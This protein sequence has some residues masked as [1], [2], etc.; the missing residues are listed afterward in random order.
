[1]SF[2]N[3]ICLFAGAALLAAA[4]GC[5]QPD[6]LAVFE[7][8]PRSASLQ[9]DALELR[10]PEELQPDLPADPVPDI[11]ADGVLNLSVEEVILWALRQNRDLRVQQYNPLI[12]GTFEQLER[13][14]FDPELFGQ[15]DYNEEQTTETARS[16]GTQFNVEATGA[17]G[18]AGIRQLLPT[19]TDIE[20]GIEQQ[21]TVSN[22]APE[23]QEA[24]AGLTVT[25]ALLRGFGPAVN[26]VGVRQAELET[27]ANIYELRGFTEALLAEAE[28]AYWYYVLADREIAIFEQSLDIAR[29]QRDEILQRIEVGIMPSIE[30]A[31][32]RAEVA[33]REQ[34]LINARS[35]LR[36]RRLRL[37]RIMGPRFANDPELRIKAASTPDIAPEPIEDLD[38]RLQLALRSRADLH[39]ANLRLKQNRLETILTRNGLLPKLDLFISLG[40][41]GFADTFSDSFKALDGSTYDFTAG[42]RLNHFLGNRAAEARH[43]AARATRQQGREAVRNLEELIGL[44]VRLAVNEVERARQQISASRVTRELQEKSLSAEKERFDVGASTALLVAQAQRDHLASLIAEVEAVIHYRLALIQLYLAEGSLLE[45]RGIS[46]DIKDAAELL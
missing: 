27:T 23:Q 46:L 44:D 42:V 25:Q 29:Q 17:G 35:L 30:A 32:A 18:G 40:K 1:M 34:L 14:R 21:R 39:E 20:A 9:E 13:G 41:T 16:T 28:T 38:N 7:D 37:L 11:P 6:R 36:E 2:Q 15:I 43:L 31:A 45:R 5:A 3:T 4:A 10:I 8:Y 12:A 24:R 19:G 33:R 26:L 22:R